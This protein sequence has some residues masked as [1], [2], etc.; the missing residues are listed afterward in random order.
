MTAPDRRTIDVYEAKAADYAAMP[1]TE[2]Q[3]R[4]LD[5]F[6]DRLPAGAHILDLGCGPG[7]QAE[8]MLRRGFSVDAID[9][10]PGFVAAA[11]A[12]GVAARLARFDEIDAIAQYDAVWASF[13][14]LHAPR[15][16]LRGH[17][18]AL[19]RALRPGGLLHLGMKLGEG[20]A[21]DPLGRLYTYVTADEAEGLVA[22]AGLAI[23]TRE[24]GVSRGLAGTEDPFILLTAAKAPADA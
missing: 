23:L 22:G 10:A 9:A 16:D 13:S 19:A 7:L 24:T 12:R 15:A 1:L 18:A 2:G 8:R 14:L 21:R 5:G 6:L 4:S 3:S 11:R 17:L 20:A